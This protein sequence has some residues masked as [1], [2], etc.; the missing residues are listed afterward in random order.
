MMSSVGCWD[1]RIFEKSGFVL[2]ISFES[3]SSNKILMTFT[4]PVIEPVAKEQTELI[5][6]DANLLREFREIARRTSAKLLVG[7]KIQ[8]ILISDSLAY[9]G[10]NTLLEVI[11]RESTDPPVAY[12]VIVEGSP[13]S[14][15]EAAVKFEDKPH[16]PALYIQQL[17]EN[18]IRS[19]YIPETRIFQFSTDYFSPGI[20][21]IAPTIKLQSDKGKGIE[22][23]GTALFHGDK[24]AGKIDTK[25]T[26][27][28]LAMM[29]KMK[30]PVFISKRLLGANS[31]N[32]KNGCA[33]TFNKAKR[34]LSVK[35][36]ED[37]PIVDLTL[38]LKG[39]I[40][41][42]KW[43]RNYDEN[44]Q[45]S[46][47]DMLSSEIKE[48]CERVIKYTQMVGSDPLGIGDIVRAR[49][50]KYWE[51]VSWDSAYKDAVFQIKVN[52]NIINH[53]VIR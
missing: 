32:G 4:T 13:K 23:T 7:G 34:K 28:L 50:N 3:S 9:K 43:D 35:I 21:P 39:T 33:V 26:S 40:G 30:K 16:I 52:V 24:M 42:L 47:E 15:I 48:N 17:I 51:K 14:L 29:G 27:L 20:D 38:N 5:Y 49:H 44:I 22:V 18:N 2:Q 31:E 25:Q 6:S 11:E 1:Q 12:V 46:M 10:I 45:G 37:R 19:S 53:G 8:Q 36:I 41:E